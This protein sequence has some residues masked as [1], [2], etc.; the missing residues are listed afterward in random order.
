MKEKE[1]T[2]KFS[3]KEAGET[4]S[5]LLKVIMFG[6][7]IFSF[8]KDLKK[9]FHTGVQFK[10]M[11]KN[12]LSKQNSFFKKIGR[13]PSSTPLESPSMKTFVIDF[14][15]NIP[16]FIKEVEFLLPALDRVDTVIV[17]IESPGGS[18]VDYSLAT[19]HLERL[20][21]TGVHLVASIDRVAASGGYMMAVVADE[22]YATPHSIVGSIGVV[23]SFPNFSKA[24]SKLGVTWKEYTAGSSKRTAGVFRKMS[25]EDDKKMKEKLEEMHLSFIDHIKNYRR[26]DE[27]K[28]ATGDYWYSSIS[29][30]K[31]LNLVD[32]IK[33]SSEVISE[34]LEYTEV[35]EVVTVEQQ[36][37][38]GGATRAMVKA[39]IEQITIS[40]N[41]NRAYL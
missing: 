39:F 5:A 4:I 24:L 21:M 3:L 40:L 28:V 29:M 27:S 26:I 38:F 6:F 14:K 30:D 11:N 31:N 10:S 32:E 23:N 20:K 41:L 19:Y 9:S 34:H 16:K 25:P 36:G 13:R 8:S 17:K 37:L 33:S 22:I 7:I 12:I 35:I 18:V 15:G 1:K 2:N